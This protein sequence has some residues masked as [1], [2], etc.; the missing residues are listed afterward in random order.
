M[1]SNVSDVTETIAVAL[2]LEDPAPHDSIALYHG[3]SMM[4][5]SGLNAAPAGTRAIVIHPRWMSVSRGLLAVVVFLNNVFPPSIL[6]SGNTPLPV[7]DVLVISLAVPHAIVCPF[8][9]NN[10]TTGYV[11]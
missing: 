6:M 1:S 9:S 4:I 3:F 11:L 5:F 2:L 8:V 10:A 7:P